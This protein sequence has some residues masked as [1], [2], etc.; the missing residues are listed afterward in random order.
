[1]GVPGALTLFRSV[2]KKSSP[3]APAFYAR[4]TFLR[5]R[6]LQ[7]WWTLLHPPYSLMHLSFV[8]LGACLAP[9]VNAA[10]LG[11]S[12]SAF[13]LG[14]GV[15]AHALDE[16][17][18]RPLSTSI[19][20]WQLVVASFVGL[21]GAVALGV[22]GVFLVSPYL[23]VFIVIG[24]T[25][26]VGYNLELFHSRLH[27]SAVFALGW[28]GFPVLTAYFAEHTTISVAAFVAAIY[29]SLVA[30][31]QRHL[32]SFARMLRRR[33]ASL[34]GHR[35]LLDGTVEPFTEETVLTPLERALSSLCWA[36]SALAV[37][38]L[39]LRFVGV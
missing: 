4:P 36:S 32:S 27:T 34:E 25:L 2:P 15:G 30:L 23:V 13:F 26:A 28:G 1:M 5:R 21:G 9:P 8:V 17:K 19:P 37:A 33:T 10:R 12:V 22:V 38:V 29:A 7:E 11:A 6:A 3:R 24:V 20:T 35:I 16:L 14:V 18:G 31:T 39:A